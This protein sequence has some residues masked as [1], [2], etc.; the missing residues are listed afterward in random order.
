MHYKVQLHGIRHP[1][2]MVT[3]NGVVIHATYLL[4]W[5]LGHE[6]FK[7]HEILKIK[8]ARWWALSARVDRPDHIDWLDY[9]GTPS[10]HVIED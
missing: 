3:S 10:G 1:S 2:F 5:T 4:A 9:A 8:N 6:F 7:V